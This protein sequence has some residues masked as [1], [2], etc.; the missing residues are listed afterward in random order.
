M[1]NISSIPLL[2]L[3]HKF[4]TLLII[5]VRQILLHGFDQQF[6]FGIIQLHWFAFLNRTDSSH[7]LE[8]LIVDGLLCFLAV[9]IVEASVIIVNTRPDSEMFAFLNLLYMSYHVLVL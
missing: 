9:E 2:H 8:V 7:H 4:L 5:L 1:L 3:N 6:V